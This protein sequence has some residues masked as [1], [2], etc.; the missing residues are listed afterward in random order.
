MVGIID[1]GVGN[2]FSLQSSFKA[3]GEEA[4]VSGDAEKLAKADRLV[5]RIAPALERVDK[6]I[7]APAE[8]LEEVYYALAAM[9]NKVD[10]RKVSLLLTTTAEVYVET[11]RKDAISGAA[12]ETMREETL[13]PSYWSARYAASYLHGKVGRD[14]TTV[15]YTSGA[16]VRERVRLAAC[17]DVNQICLASLEGVTAEVLDA[18][19]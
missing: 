11:Q 18:L 4:F 17:F 13:L 10:M 5:L 12:V 1:Y 8:P 15:W 9:N 14:L 6:V 3:I 19:K 7:L 16:G 2:L